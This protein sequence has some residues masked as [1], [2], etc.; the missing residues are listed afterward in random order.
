MRIPLFI[1]GIRTGLF[2]TGL[3]TEYSGHHPLSHLFVNML[4]DE[5]GSVW[6]EFSAVKKDIVFSRSIL[7]LTVLSG[8]RHCELAAN[9]LFHG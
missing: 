6:D 4:F 9:T 3:R 7:H 2:Q 5:T 1:L 8:I